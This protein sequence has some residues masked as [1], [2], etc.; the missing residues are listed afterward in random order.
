MRS[1]L[2]FGSLKTALVTLLVLAALLAG[3]GPAPARDSRPCR[4]KLVF[5]LDCSGSMFSGSQQ[6][7]DPEGQGEITLM[8]AMV[9]FLSRLAEDRSH[10]LFRAADQLAVYGFYSKLGRLFITPSFNP[11]TDLERFKSIGSIISPSSRY[12]M[13]ESLNPRFCATQLTDFT[14]VVRHIGDEVDRTGLN[15]GEG[16]RQLIFVVLT[17]G[18]H[19]TTT[20]QEFRAELDAVKERLRPH[21]E[22]GL[23]KIVF[24][25]LARP[26]G[27]AGSFD[28]SSDFNSVLG[29]ELVLV[30][31]RPLDYGAIVRGIRRQRND[32]V[33]FESFH[34]RRGSDG[35]PKGFSF[36]L[37][38][39]SCRERRVEEL[40]LTLTRLGPRDKEAQKDP[41]GRVEFPEKGIGFSALL[42][43]WGEEGYRT[44]QRE[45]DLEEKGFL[46]P[47]LAEG[48]YEI[49]ARLEFRIPAADE[50]A[51]VEFEYRRPAS[52][53]LIY[54][55]II[56]AIVGFLLKYFGVFPRKGR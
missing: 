50:T 47:D 48:V 6:V 42:A 40:Y 43:P 16:V 2:R 1:S 53:A 30:D 19:D 8:E 38:N 35:L 51:K 37:K 14:N 15:R 21:L 25:S 44:E 34:L 26:A 4:D 20:H 27:T 11:D 29:A 10:G 18:L 41:I 31:Q 52:P 39:E 13:G 3:P 17:D 49:S 33:R 22:S 12:S 54:L 9:K 28:V 5:Y 56:L 23:V 46:P 55:L 32:A 36:R 24:V 7:A 45:I